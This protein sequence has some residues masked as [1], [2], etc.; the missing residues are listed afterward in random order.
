MPITYKIIIFIFLFLAILLLIDSNRIADPDLFCHLYSGKEIIEKGEVHSMDTHS[1]SVH[2]SPWVD[3]EWM[4]RAVFYLLYKQFGSAGIVCLRLLLSA[5]LIFTITMNAKRLSGSSTLSIFSVMLGAA[6]FYRYFLFRPQLFTFLLLSFLMFSLYQYGSNRKKI[7]LYFFPLLFLLWSNIHGGFPLG[8]CILGL[9]ILSFFI[10]K[11]LP[12]K[13]NFEKFH[14]S[15]RAMF[16]LVLVSIISLLVTLINPYGIDLW[17]GILGTVLGT[18]TPELSEW[19]PAFAFPFFRLFWF[20]FFVLIYALA[21]FFSKQRRLFDLFLLL[22]LVYLSLTKVRFVP[23]MAILLTPS[24]SYYLKKAGD[25]TSSRWEKAPLLKLFQ[26]LPSFYLLFLI[27]SIP[28]FVKLYQGDIYLN[29]YI[30]KAEAFQ[31]IA[32]VKLLKDNDFQGHIMNEYDWGGYIH[33]EL[34]ES[35]I[36]VDGRSDTVYPHEVINRWASF[37]NGEKGWEHFLETTEADAILIRTQ[38]LVNDQLDDL[39]HWQLIYFDNIAALYMNV[40]SPKNALFIKK[41]IKGSLATSKI[42]FKDRI[43]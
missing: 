26:Q 27:V 14:L 23:L 19:K 35:K 40:E 18:F 10:E 29:G 8:L 32:P 3:Y 21:F 34:P 16:F 9:F 33:W 36:F 25:W 37:V 17:K 24:L 28:I 12:A 4:A 15:F 31:T 22:F 1:F 7:I 39:K 41:W 5:L 11:W 30:Y 42:T 43:L 2:G 38:H 6:A 13:A 20:Y